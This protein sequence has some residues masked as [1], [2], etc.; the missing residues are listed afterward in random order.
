MCIVPHHPAVLLRLGVL[1]ILQVWHEV[2]IVGPS[3]YGCSEA[4]GKISTCAPSTNYLPEYWFSRYPAKVA[5]IWNLLKLFDRTS[6]ILILLSIISVT[7]F[8]FISGKVGTSCFGIRTFRAE[9][10]LSPFR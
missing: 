8:F 3:D 5:P 1:P 10:I 9:I 4:R 6:W 2:D 7:I